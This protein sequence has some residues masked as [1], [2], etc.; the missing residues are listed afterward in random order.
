M[1]NGSV[2]SLL[3]FDVRVKVRVE[4]ICEILFRA[5]VHTSARVLIWLNRDYGVY[6]Y[7]FYS[8]NEFMLF[9]LFYAIALIYKGLT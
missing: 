8:R 7:T 1:R 3:A 4:R 5:G 2:C 9:L 6:F